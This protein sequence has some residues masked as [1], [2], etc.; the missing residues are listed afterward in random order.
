MAEPDDGEG[1]G[2]GCTAQRYEPRQ[3]RSIERAVRPLVAG[4]EAGKV[5]C[6]YCRLREARWR[7]HFDAAAPRIVHVLVYCTQCHK[8]GVADL[9]LDAPEGRRGCLGRS[10]AAL[11]ALALFAL[12]LL[13][14]LL[15]A[16]EQV[17]ELV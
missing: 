5:W 15:V 1:L 4:A 10:A 3:M 16:A 11:L 2:A 12:L 9:D 8:T 7:R 13:A 6:P 14:L 17:A